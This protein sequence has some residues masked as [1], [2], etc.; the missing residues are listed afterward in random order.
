MQDD[1]TMKLKNFLLL[2]TISLFS[3]ISSHAYALEKINIMSEEYPPYN[4]TI[5]TND[6]KKFLTGYAVELLVTVFKKIN[7]PQSRE[8]IKVLP[9][10][11]SYKL[12]QTEGLQNML[13]VTTRTKERETLFNWVGPI[14]EFSIVILAKKDSNINSLTKKDLN[15]YSYTT[16]RDDIGDILL[17]SHGVLDKN[18]ERRNNFGLVLKAVDAGRA[19]MIAYA[20]TPAMALIR[21]NKKDPKDYKVV[22]KL[23][24][25]YLYYAFNKSVDQKIL[26]AYQQG[27]NEVKKDKKFIGNLKEKYL[28]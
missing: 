7:A 20:K 3:V 16:V 6:D 15:N 14:V 25:S 18:I 2:L 1:I 5:K 9:W 21:K 26:D 13:F 10:A 17:S 8:K 24:T 27:L 4:Y 19:D 28:N 11:R 23:Q 22:Y 12:A